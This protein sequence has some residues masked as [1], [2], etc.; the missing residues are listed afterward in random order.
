METVEDSLKVLM[1]MGERFV[2]AG[3]CDDDIR[4]GNFGCHVDEALAKSV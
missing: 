3:G 1:G 4:V 2:V